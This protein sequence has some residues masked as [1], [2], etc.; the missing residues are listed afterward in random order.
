MHAA[1]PQ[2]FTQENLAD[3]I[4]KNSIEQRTKTEKVDLTEEKVAELEHKSSRAS[5][6]IDEL[7]E[8]KKQFI[9][10][11]KKGTTVDI[12]QVVADDTEPKRKPVSFTIP[13]TKGLD[14]LT[15]NRQFADQQLR[16]G[17]TTTEKTIY[18]IP[19]PEEKTIVGFDIEGNEDPDF[20]R[21]MTDDERNY[22]DM[23]IITESKKENKKEKKKKQ[24]LDGEDFT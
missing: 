10:V 11:L 17:C 9:E 16:D 3:W 14:A 8:I 23:P 12:D 15:A 22:Y 24:V 13:P 18:H 21:E 7:N 20:N 6:S 1:L 4:V 5:Q 19:F 2:T